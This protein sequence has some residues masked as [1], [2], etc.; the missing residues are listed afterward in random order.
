MARKV[1]E[2]KKVEVKTPVKVEKPKPVS[3]FA[4]AYNIRVTPRKTRLV[5]DLVRGKKVA[6]AL[7][8][9][10]NVNKAASPDVVKVIKSA[11]ANAVHNFGF[12]KDKLYISE[13]WANEGMRM[14]RSMPRARGSATLIIKRMSHLTCVVKERD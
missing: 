11:A 2:E 5:I 1:K 7:G 13:I 14:K 9:L 6:D 8:I 4:I 10:A 3:A 12:N